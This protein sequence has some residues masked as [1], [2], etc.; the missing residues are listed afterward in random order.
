M[1]SAGDARNATFGGVQALRAHDMEDRLSV[2]DDA[3]TRSIAEVDD[4]HG[5]IRHDFGIV[6]DFDPVRIAVGN[7]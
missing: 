5:R 4:I 1:A 7:P 6:E 3:G 2:Q